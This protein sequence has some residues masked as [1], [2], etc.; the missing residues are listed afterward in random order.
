MTRSSR[1]P[2]FVIIGAAKAATTW[3]T[4]QLRVRP[5][6]FMPSPEPHYFS[7]EYERGEEWYASWFKDSHADQLVGE[8]SADY[9]ADPR[10]AERMSR[11]LPDAQIVV[12]L[13]NPV[14]RAYSDYC[15]LFRRGTVNGEIGKFLGSQDNPQPRF[16]NDGLYNQ[17][18]KRFLDHFPAAN[19]KTIL[20]E[21][22]RKTPEE[23]VRNVN[24]FL[25]LPDLGHEIQ[26]VERANVKD[27]PLL[28]L[29]MRRTLAPA[30]RLVAPLR[31]KPWFKAIHGTLAREV[32]YPQ[33]SHDLKQSMRDFYAKDVEGLGTLLQRDL[34]HWLSD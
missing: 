25:G 17:H 5:D 31:S 23:V 21:D 27:A 20:Y 29:A 11:L 9:L 7:R 6:V 30:K 15:M 12:Q 33:L 4:N 34:S 10:A 19:I 32:P 28:P 22:I 26:L 13:R 18:L 3:V 2:D 16:L 14:D 1:L 8:K 24:M